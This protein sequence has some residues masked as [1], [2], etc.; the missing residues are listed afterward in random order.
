[1]GAAALP[2]TDTAPGAAFTPWLPRFS[3]FVTSKHHIAAELLQHTDRTNPLFGNSRAH[4]MAD[5]QPLLDAA[6]QA[7]EIRADLT[8]EQ[9][10]DMVIAIATIHGNPSYLE[11]I[12]IS[13]RDGLSAG[14]AESRQR[15]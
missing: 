15:A 3:A 11:L 5:G 4:V 8:L 13:A 2:A 14:R 1:M 10:L 6:Q 12:L 9:I 7:M